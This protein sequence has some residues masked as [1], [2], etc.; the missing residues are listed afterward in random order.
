MSKARKCGICRKPADHGNAV[1]A[2]CSHEHGAELAI[3]LKA[4]ADKRK[5][6]SQRRDQREARERIKTG[7]TLRKE[8]QAAFNA[9]VRARDVGKPC[10]SCGRPDDGHHQRHAGHYRSAG[11]HPAL[12]FHPDNC[13][14]QCATCN[15]HLSGNLVPYRAEL[16]RRIGLARVEWLEGPHELPKLSRQELADI[17]AQYRRA[18]NKSPATGEQA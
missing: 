17:K 6:A 7:P 8:A 10:V 3:R 1:N 12:R 18:A 9:W 13:H 14:A 15:N 16:I 4:R 5:A 2:W 11:G